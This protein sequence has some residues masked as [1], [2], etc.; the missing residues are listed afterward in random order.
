MK[1]SSSAVSKGTFRSGIE[2]FDISMDLA[3]FGE[4]GCLSLHLVSR[5]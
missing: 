5:D 4:S 1:V 3:L 2:V